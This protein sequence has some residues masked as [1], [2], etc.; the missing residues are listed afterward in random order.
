MK[1]EH[2]LKIYTPELRWDLLLMARGFAGHDGGRLGY[3]EANKRLVAW[4]WLAIAEAPADWSNEA[5]LRMA[6]HEMYRVYR[7]EIKVFGY[8]PRWATWDRAIRRVR[9]R[10]SVKK[11]RPNG[12]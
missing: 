2:L 6:L 5:Y 7:E 12:Q 10:F 9:C 11:K 3:A 1:T 4:G 8:R